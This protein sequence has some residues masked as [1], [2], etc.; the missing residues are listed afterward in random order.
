MLVNFNSGFMVPEGNEHNEMF[1]SG[2]IQDT[3][4]FIQF[5]A[6]H[7]G[8]TKGY[9]PWCCFS[10]RAKDRTH[11]KSGMTYQKFRKSKITFHVSR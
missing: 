4:A 11:E 6:L 1:I 2:E 5:D 10:I 8:L 7:D 3:I 9:R